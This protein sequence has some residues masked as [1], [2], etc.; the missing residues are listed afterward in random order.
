MLVH[1]SKSHLQTFGGYCT[2]FKTDLCKIHCK[3]KG[4]TQTTQSRRIKWKKYV[5]FF[6]I[7][8]LFIIYDVNLYALVR[9]G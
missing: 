4:H 3:C 6:P 7:I 2:T 5:T 1:L 9:T 8:S